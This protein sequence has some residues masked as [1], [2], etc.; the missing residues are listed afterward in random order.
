M[1]H[2][3]IVNV[4]P[5]RF[6][7]AGRPGPYRRGTVRFV[8]AGAGRNEPRADTGRTPGILR[9][10][11]RLKGS[12]SMRSVMHRRAGPIIGTLI[13]TGVFIRL[14]GRFLLGR[15]L[16]GERRTDATFFRPGTKVLSERT[17]SGRWALLA[18]WQRAAVRTVL[19]FGT[20]TFVYLYYVRPGAALTLGLTA[21]GAAAGIGGV[22][23]FHALRAWRHTR[24]VVRPLHVAL[25]RVLA[26]SPRGRRPGEWINVPRNYLRDEETVVR[27]SLP[28]DFHPSA[29]M[30]KM[31]YTSAVS[32][33][34]GSDWNDQWKVFG[35][36]PLL[37]LRRAPQPPALV[38]FAAMRPHMAGAA[39]N[40]P[41]IGL[42]AR[43]A[44]ISADLD[45]DSPHILI[46]AGSGGGK[47]TLVKAV[48]AH[49]LRHGSRVVILDVKRNSHVWA[50]GLPGV[51]Y[52]R[53]IEAIH[54]ALIDLAGEMQE[55]FEIT[56]DDP[57]AIFQRIYVVCEEMNLTIAELAAYWINTRDKDDPKGSP[58]VDA[59]RKILFAGRA[60]RMNVV[61]VA[62][63]M[64]ARAIGG[65]EA[66]ENFA[67]RC[68]TRYTQNAWKMLAPEVWPMPRSPRRGQ[69]GRW[70]IVTSG[71]ARS[72]QVGFL[73]DEEARNWA[74][75]GW[76]VPASQD[77]SEQAEEAV[78]VPGHEP[79]AE[80]A[81]GPAQPRRYT[82]REA[83]DAGVVALTYDAIRKARSRDPEFPPGQDGRE[84]TYTADELTAWERNRPRATVA[85]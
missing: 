70:Q 27:I 14:S 51:T 47:S 15:P 58:S 41:V 69:V 61:A 29:D 62:Q 18:G 63:S 73:T 66:R 81:Q 7:V 2:A 31:V 59:L 20:A 37:E 3:G 67:F 42:G 39:E 48:A 82:L 25:S 34:G 11:L 79:A 21:A 68:L 6:G 9:G 80:S 72:C 12:Q 32:R 43:K 85:P 8:R 60:A 65:P 28:A 45:A 54:A 36:K 57:D 77:G 33:L 74:R 30:K 64:S 1:D 40:A 52:V 55:R 76:P 19:T 84:R 83:C 13:L 10:L 17:Y 5:L 26:V 23:G 24:T 16:D 46:S 75:L 35:P 78:T 44:S 50:R 4:P 71:E 49:G 22:R 38:D 56:D 53:D